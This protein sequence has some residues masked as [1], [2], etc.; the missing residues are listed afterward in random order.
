MSMSRKDYE[1]IA[2]HIRD[3]SD[4]D[5]LVCRLAQEFFEQ[6]PR[7]DKRMFF[8]ATGRDIMDDYRVSRYGVIES[9]GKFEGEMFYMPL[10]YSEHNHGNSVG[11]DGT[12]DDIWKTVIEWGGEEKLIYFFEDNVGFVHEASEEAVLAG[13]S[14]DE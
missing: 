14:W 10:A 4:M 8:M 12:D 7:F 9:P 2:E 1:V 5:E 13:S 6:N 11:V 3:A